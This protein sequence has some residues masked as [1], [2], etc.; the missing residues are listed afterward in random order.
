MGTLT[1][2]FARLADQTWGVRVNGPRPTEGAAITV[3][4]RDGSTKSATVARVL[5]HGTARDGQIASL[6][7]IVEDSSR[8]THS[9]CAPDEFSGHGRARGGGGRRECEECGDYVVR[10][11]V[12][13]DT[14]CLH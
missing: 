9:N 8:T 1:A 7:S 12:C 2:T 4:K 5:W 11:T 3:A 10:G 13:W 6:C 14:G